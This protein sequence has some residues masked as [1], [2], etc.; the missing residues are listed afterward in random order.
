M[1]LHERKD[2]LIRLKELRFEIE[3]SLY[4]VEDIKVTLGYKER[5]R[6]TPVTAC[7]S[8]IDALIESQEETIRVIEVD[9]P[10]EESNG[11]DS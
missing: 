5:W 7:I 2:A 9:R 3:N 4:A 1:K 10:K 11:T 8:H 6:D